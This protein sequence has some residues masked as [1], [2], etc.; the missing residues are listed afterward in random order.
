MAE[1]LVVEDEESSLE[2]VTAVLEQI[3]HQVSGARSAEEAVD[4]LRSSRPAVV[5]VDIRLP[6]QDGLAL[7]RQLKADPATATIPVVAL[8]AHARTEDREA[9]LAAGCS[10]WITKPLDTHLLAH[11]LRQVLKGSGG[12]RPS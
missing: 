6:G 9:A 2:L 10:Y 7:T 3:G 11:T 4:L 1:V 5:L 8:T 12:S